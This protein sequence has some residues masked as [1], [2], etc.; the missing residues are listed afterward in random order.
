[1]TNPIHSSCPK[2]GAPIP[3]NAPQ[4]LCPKCVLA[5]AA[6]VPQPQSSPAGRTPAPSI[7]ELAPHFP[8][9]EILEVIGI[10]G[11]GAVYKARQP[12]LDRLVALKILSSDLS[13]DP[14]FAE[15]FNREARVLARLNH[16]NIVTVFDFGTAGPFCFLLME[17]VD[18]VNLRQAMR[19]G[20]FTPTESLSLVQ[21]ICTALKFAHEA[22]ILHRDIKPENVL[23]D[24][25]G[26]VKIADFGI[27]KLVGK[28]ERDDATLTMHGAVLGTPHYMAPEQIETPGD[29]DQ[30]ADIYSLGVVFYELLTRELPIGRF[31]PPSERSPMDPRIDE[32]VMRALEKDRKARYQTAE[33]VRTSV[34][35]LA[36]SPSAPPKSR[37][38][39][40]T[41]EH[42]AAKF[43]LA[44][45]ILTGISLPLTMI[46]FVAVSG[47]VQ[48]PPGPVEHVGSAV[49]VGAILALLSALATLCCAVI[50]FILG[51]RALGEIR[52]SG[53]VKTGLGSAIFATTAW[54]IVFLFFLSTVSMKVL[55]SGE[56]PTFG[57]VAF[58]FIVL[59]PVLVAAW[60]L[61]RS[62]YRWAGGVE[63]KDGTRFHPGFGI[64]LLMA[65]LLPIGGPLLMAEIAIRIFPADS[66]RSKSHAF[67]AARSE[68]RGIE[69]KSKV[70]VAAG[71]M[72]TFRLV[73]ID[74]RGNETPVEI[75]GTI[76]A[77]QD[78]D[79]QT[80][81]S[82]IVKEPKMDK[83]DRMRELTASCELLRG[84]YL[85]TVYFEEDWK[86]ITSGKGS[87]QLLEEQKDRLEL[88]TR[89]NWR[90]EKVESLFLETVGVPEKTSDGAAKPG[91]STEK[92][93]EGEKQL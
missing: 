49:S 67:N 65:M 14:A 46:V 75:G 79:F 58:I 35:A 33:E 73:R 40:Q 44:A 41:G 83:S 45:A 70:R 4:G 66:R 72:I 42:P 8:E 43:S 78:R 59:L 7:A 56:G 36:Q 68:E 2:C 23:I 77:P 76:Y 12:K 52:R 5:G 28:D 86:F 13:K 38:P 92:K 16:P 88:A 81:L 30:R 6:T 25:R 61:V 64:P 53:G 24:S 60:L 91:A 15:R 17:Y 29:V 10:G 22:G 9:L 21:D 18:G 47:R 84:A 89:E 50:G 37:A 71:K 3:E 54:P 39:Q 31:A 55:S 62:L 20:G 48:G 74:A 1:M 87:H 32:I 80:T 51:A 11:M 82:I 90:G 69:L 85:K 19:A 63:R 57:P 93:A 26:R 34:G 27:A